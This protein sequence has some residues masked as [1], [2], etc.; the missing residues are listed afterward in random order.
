MIR[1]V[2]LPIDFSNDS[3]LVLRFVS[4]LGALGVRRVVCGHVIDVTGLEGPVIAAKVDSVREQMRLKVQPMIDAGLDVEVR[5]PTGD[6][7][8]ELLS[9]A[10]ETH[11]DAIVVGTSGKSVADQLIVGSV[12]ERL[13][14]DAGIPTLT[15][16]F[17]ILHNAADPAA[18]AASFGHVVLVP[19]D[20]SPT[21][22]RAMDV[23]LTL[24][25]RAVNSVRILH[26]LPNDVDEARRQRCEDGAD[27]QL[28]NLCDRAKEAGMS[29]IPVIGTGDPERAIAR[30]ISDSGVTG[31][32]IGSHGRN[33]LQEA[34]MGSVSM[35]LLRQAS[36]PVL[37]VP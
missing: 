35:T 34:F 14:R 8:R 23:A 33:P 22:D 30:D 28:R 32:V 26:V 18:V 13:V 15:V 24:P 29:A 21:A 4:G 31:V 9:L 20:F 11:V 16:R 7:E 37:I 17:D 3:T 10:L 2:L 27:F 36:C 25:A 1:T 19:T 5:I 6:P 12:S